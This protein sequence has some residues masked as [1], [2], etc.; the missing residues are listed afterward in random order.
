MAEIRE[1]FGMKII[2]TEAI[3]NESLDSGRAICRHDPDW[4][5]QHAELFFAQARRTRQKAPCC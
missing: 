4:R 2:V 3:D 5:A 1:Q